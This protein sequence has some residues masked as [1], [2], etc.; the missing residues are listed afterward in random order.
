MSLSVG[1]VSREKTIAIW[2]KYKYAIIVSWR[3][4]KQEITS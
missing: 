4:K 3:Y 1:D 2:V